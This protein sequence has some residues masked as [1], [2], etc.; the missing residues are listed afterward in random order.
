MVRIPFPDPGFGFASAMLTIIPLIVF[1]GFAYV[2]GS[3]LYRWFVNETSPR[4]E[5][6]ATVMAKRTHV[7]GGGHHHH[8][9]STSYYITFQ[10]E[11]GGRLELPV[12]GSDFGVLFEGDSGLLNY[13]GTRF[14]HFQ[15]GQ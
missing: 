4:E 12:N 7:S 13:Q 15:R 9:A 10:F 5:R 3:M 1:G 14:N 8:H 11:D 6:H 2:I